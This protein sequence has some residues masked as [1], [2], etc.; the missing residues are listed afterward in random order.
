MN[1]RRRF[2]RQSFASV[3]GAIGASALAQQSSPQGENV[4]FGLC[5]Y[6]LGAEW[7]IPTIIKNLTELQI[8]GVELRMDHA[9]K[10]SP[11][12][13]SE[14]RA[15]VK[16]QFEDSGIEL[17]GLGT[18]WAFDSPDPEKLR[19]NIGEAKLWI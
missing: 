14:E 6:M 10:V 7:D 18:N 11:A 4:S 12:L 17:V 13:K 15:R 16:A 9:H 5:T 8:G 1:T 2:I 19:T 3:A